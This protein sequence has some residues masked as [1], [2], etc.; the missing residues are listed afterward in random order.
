MSIV[1]KWGRER[2]VSPHGFPS[3][4]SLSDVPS[5]SSRRL[6]A[7]ASLRTFNCP[8]SVLLRLHFSLPPPN[9]KLGELRHEIAE[10]T[11]LPGQ[12]FKLIHAG[13]VMK[14]DN[15]PSTYPSARMD[16]ASFCL[17]H[18]TRR[19]WHRRSIHECAIFFFHLRVT[20][21]SAPGSHPNVLPR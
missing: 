20:V 7:T 10:Y 19:R 15:A 13:A 8:L 1:V 9:A 5:V 3:L 18:C 2:Y 12:S 21:A 11:Q 14:D 4:S 6:A 16:K 17:L